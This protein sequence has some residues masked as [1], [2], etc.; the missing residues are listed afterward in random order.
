MDTRLFYDGLAEMYHTLYHD[1]ER[2]VTEQAQTLIRLLGSPPPGAALADTACGIGTQLIGLS[3]AGYR[4]FGTDISP[5]AIDRAR[6]ECVARGLLAELQVADMS[7]LP[8]ADASMDGAVCADNSIP[9]LLSDDQVT[10]AFAELNRVLRP[11][12]RAVVTTRDYDTILQT[13]PQSTLP[14]VMHT[15]GGGRTVS[16]QLWAWR[17]TSDIYDVELFQLQEGRDHTWVT[18]RRTVTYRA[19]TRDHLAQL[20]A[21]ADLLDPR[22]LPPSESQYF[23]P[24]MVATRRRHGQIAL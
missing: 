14:Q 23:Q 7:S 22:W 2:A 21:R 15:H 16:F 5:T 19:Y 17:Q 11:G 9:H 24:V 8:W 4:M 18:T 6:R 1:W 10:M 20:A 13:R 3:A 12:A